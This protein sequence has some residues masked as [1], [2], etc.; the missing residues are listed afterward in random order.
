MKERFDIR[1]LTP[2]RWD[3]IAA[4]FGPR[5]ACGGCWCM[6][7]RVPRREF[8]TKKGAGNRRTFRRIVA[9]GEIPGLI[10]YRDGAPVGW[11]CVGPRERF[12]VLERSRT[13]R[14]VDDLPVWSIVCFFID[15]RWRRRGVARALVDA[16]VRRAFRHGAP[17]VEAYPVEPR[18]GT[19]PDAFAW[20]GVGSLFRSAGFEEAARRSAA[21]AVMRRYRRGGA[22]TGRPI[23]REAARAREGSAG[24]SCS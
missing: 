20:T 18:S 2:G 7:W 22:G 6:W 11:C 13:L 17:A 8:E 15:R 5:G 14:R 9:S 19:M 10:A 4:L 16:A 1:P 21:R 24:K 3:D 12:P 23:S